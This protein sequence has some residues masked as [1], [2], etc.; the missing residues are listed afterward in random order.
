MKNFKQFTTIIVIVICIQLVFMMV[1]R[2]RISSNSQPPL[3]A[4]PHSRGVYD[5]SK[6]KNFKQFTTRTRC[7]YTI[8]AVFMMVQRWRISSNSQQPLPTS[9]KCWRC[10]WWFKDEEFQAIHNWSGRHAGMTLGVY[11]GS[12]MKNFKQFTTNQAFVPRT[13]RCLW[14]FKDEEFQAIHNC[15]LQLCLYLLGVYDGSKMKNF[16]QFTTFDK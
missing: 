11:D 14:W 9:L 8:L 4:V 16:K 7:R 13:W 6:M 3:R 12:K 1:Q 2:W 15:Q 10:L 5:G